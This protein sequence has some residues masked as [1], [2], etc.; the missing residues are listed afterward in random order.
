MISL[1]FIERCLWNDQN[2]PVC[3]VLDGSQSKI[4]SGSGLCATECGLVK[5]GQCFGGE[6]WIR[7]HLMWGWW[8]N[9]HLS[10][11]SIYQTIPLRWRKGYRRILTWSTWKMSGWQWRPHTHC[12]GSSVSFR[13]GSGDARC[14]GQPVNNSRFILV[15]ISLLSTENSITGHPRIT[16]Q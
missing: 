7:G 5:D 11:S 14:D 13:S 12:R 6:R 3:F 15:L 9:F 10:N 2:L 8:F 16:L 1:L 4:C